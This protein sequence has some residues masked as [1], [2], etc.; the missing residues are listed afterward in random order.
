[1]Q[2]PTNRRWLIF[3]FS[4]ATSFLL[5]FHRYTWNLIRP[6]LQEEYNFTN[7][8]LELLGTAFYAT[9][10]IGQIPSGIISDL[11][12]THLFLVVIIAAWT[13]TLPLHGLSGQLGA[14]TGVRLLFG[15]GQAGAYPALGQVTRTWFPPGARTQMQGWVASF[16]GRGGGAMSSIVMATFL[17]G[18]CGLAWRTALVWMS[19][20]GLL[21]VVAMLIAFRSSPEEDPDANEA[22]CELI[23]GG[24]RT[25]DESRDIMPFGTA[26]RNPSIAILVAQQFLNAGA[27]VVYT[28]TMGSF[29]LSLGAAKSEL[30]WMVSLPLIG[31]AVGGVAGG[32][33][34]DWVIRRTGS[35]RWA[36]SGIGFA[37]KFLAA[38][39]LLGAVHLPTARWIACGLFVVKFF[40][41]WS[42]PTV[43]GTCTDIGGKYSATVFSI[44]NTSGNVGALLTPLAV[45]PLLDYYT[46]ETTVDGELQ[47]VTNFTPMFALVGGMY[48]GAAIL[49]LFLDCTRRIEGPDEE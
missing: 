36:R 25:G 6:E 24:Q 7:T 26:L 27:D 10:A 16:F 38:V 34:N 11:F 32:I 49:W 14:L 15:V 42:Q 20:P 40:T 22:E 46:V 17:M 29:F 5:Y 41:D 23:R 2:S 28:L 47:S 43:W 44:N 19:V 30:G 12:G 18:W 4:C 9:Y 8:Q 35:R 39:V 21:M 33:L 13:V 31:G 37:G 48:V 45:G 1:M 3:A